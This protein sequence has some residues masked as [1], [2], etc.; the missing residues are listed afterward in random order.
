MRTKRFIDGLNNNQK[1]RVICDGVGFYTTVREAFN[2]PLTHQRIAVTATLSSLGVRQTAL[3]NR[4]TGFATRQRVFNHEGK[5]V[6]IDVQV[7]LCE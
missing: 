7:D 6:E 2:M 4:P 1:I 3:T 5:Q